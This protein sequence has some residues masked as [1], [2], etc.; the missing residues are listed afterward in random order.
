MSSGP[1]VR[2]PEP[3]QEERDLQRQQRDLLAQ[4]VR[5]SRILAPILFGQGGL[6][7]EF[8]PQTGELV[9][10]TE[11]PTQK[12]IREGFQ[13][14]SLAALR[15][16]LPTDPTPLREL[17][18]QEA[19]LRETL[20]KQLGPGFETSTPG[21]EALQKF[22]EGRFGLIE[23]SRRGELTLAES[24]GLARQAAQSQ[25]LLQ[26]MQPKMALSQLFTAPIQVGFQERAGEFQGRLANYQRWL[27]DPFTMRNLHMGAMQTNQA[28]MGVAGGIG[29][30][31]MSTA[32]VK[33]DIEPLDRDEYRRALRKVRNM[34][35]TRWRYAWEADD[36]EPHVG[37]I[38]ELAPRE[39]RLDD[40]HLS[41]SDWLGLT[42][43]AVKGVD[44]E[45]Q[46]VKRE[47]KTLRELLRR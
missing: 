28:A 41:L 22:R 17:G 3:S 10:V 45:V 25:Q 6:V 32:R 4:Q 39:I 15:G 27:N 2:F 7:P 40:T 47:T 24:L 21:M 30:A 35:I 19:T 1:T 8:D 36:R 31:A 9:R 14:R 38:L 33:K 13:A 44:R 37:P 29:V 5:E 18:T 34:P 42:T 46:A 23:G 43:A 20:R 11:D 12:A 26:T 16:E